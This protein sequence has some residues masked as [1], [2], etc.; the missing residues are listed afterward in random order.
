MERILNDFRDLNLKTPKYCEEKVKC[1]TDHDQI[2]FCGFEDTWVCHACLYDEKIN[3][4]KH[5]IEEELTAGEFTDSLWSLMDKIDEVGS[6]TEEGKN[7]QKLVDS[8]EG[9]NLI[10]YQFW[11]DWDRAKTGSSRVILVEGLIENLATYYETF[12]EYKEIIRRITLWLLY[13]EQRDCNS[14]EAAN[15]IYRRLESDDE[16][17]KSLH[18]EGKDL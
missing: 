12:P 17:L 2:C 6:E 11:E 13:W 15:S 18:I 8:K 10:W 16:K 7:L 4:R 14:M 5:L 1:E 9:L 3:E